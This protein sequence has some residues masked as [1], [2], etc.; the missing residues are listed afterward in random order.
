MSLGTSGTGRLLRTPL[1]LACLIAVACSQTPPPEP[2]PEPPRPQALPPSAAPA[3]EQSPANPEPRSRQNQPSP[4]T[5]Q[6]EP[7]IPVPEPIMAS[8]QGAPPVIAV[9]GAALED[10]VAVHAV[11]DV[12]A[13]VVY[14][15]TARGVYVSN[16]HASSWMFCGGPLADASISAMAARSGVAYAATGSDGVFR[17]DDNGKTWTAYNK[18]LT[19]KSVNTLLFGEGN[20]RSYLFAG[21]NSGIYRGGG[22]RDEWDFVG[23]GLTD[24]VITAIGSAKGDLYAGSQSGRLYRS[25]EGWT[26]SEMTGLSWSSQVTAIVSTDDAL[27]VATGNGLF[28][29]DNGKDEWSAADIGLPSTNVAALVVSRDKSSSLYAVGSQGIW[30]SSDRGGSWMLISETT[31][32]AFDVSSDTVFYAGM[33]GEVWRTD[34]AG[35][36]WK[37]AYLK[38]PATP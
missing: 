37:V 28:R 2:P 35:K 10:G 21:T 4:V 27:Y 22:P 25:N 36:T 5:L 15:G 7:S 1:A 29:R 31:P 13:T 17:S 8:S 32:A 30:K 6:A 34:D 16:T 23:K 26:W 3:A 20:Y 33:H 9:P 38:R 11:V 18:G 12:D 14:A 19:S 24:P